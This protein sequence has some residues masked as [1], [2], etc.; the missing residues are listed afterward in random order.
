MRTG[1]KPADFRQGSDF[2]LDEVVAERLGD[3]F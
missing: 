2:A 1:I 3:G